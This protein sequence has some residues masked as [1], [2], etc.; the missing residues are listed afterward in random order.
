MR[1]VAQR[2]WF[3]LKSC[4]Q[5]TFDA[6][7]RIPPQIT[8]N[9]RLPD[10]NLSLT[11]H[12]DHENSALRFS[13]FF[14]FPTSTHPSP[15]I[16]H[17]YSNHQSQRRLCKV[18]SPTIIPSKLTRTPI[19]KAPI[20]P[21]KKEKLNNTS[22][23]TSEFCQSRKVKKS[24]SSYNVGEMLDEFGL[25]QGEWMDAQSDVFVHSRYLLILDRSYKGRSVSLLLHP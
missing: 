10:K 8:R 7:V 15:K 5:S 6:L 13:F 11:L 2:T 16:N 19:K 22:A 9:S 12:Y 24:A 14:A 4:V 3:Y 1:H 25:S 17:N 18:T 20:K 21:T 23:K